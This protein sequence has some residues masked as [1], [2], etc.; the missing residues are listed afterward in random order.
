[1]IANDVSMIDILKQ[2]LSVQKRIVVTETKLSRAAV[3]VGII[4]QD[5]K[6]HL[7]LTRR[8][9]EVETH[10]GQVAFP[11]GMMEEGET[12]IVAAMREANEEID[13]LPEEIEIIGMLNDFQTPTGFCITPVVARLI[14]AHDLTPSSAEVARIFTVPIDVFLEKKYLRIEE[15]MWKGEMRNLFLYDYDGEIIWGVSEAIIRSL[16]DVFNGRKR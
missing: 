3:L 10:K 7:L 16:I 4:M 1:M 2:N 11:G 9:D 13:L 14:V 6:P 5:E 12:P 8:T 15:R